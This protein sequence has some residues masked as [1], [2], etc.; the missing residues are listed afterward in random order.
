M[1]WWGSGVQNGQGYLQPFSS[2][3][4]TAV[5]SC[6]RNWPTAVMSPSLAAIQMFGEGISLWYGYRFFPVVDIRSKGW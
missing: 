6:A 4:L 1:R 3:E 5:G 2:C